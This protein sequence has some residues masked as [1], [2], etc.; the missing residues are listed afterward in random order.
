MQGS[1]IIV[2]SFTC[3]SF[4]TINIKTNASFKGSSRQWQQ[5]TAADG[6]E[7]SLFLIETPSSATAW[8]WIWSNAPSQGPRGM[9]SRPSTGHQHLQS[10]SK[11][12]LVGNE[13]HPCWATFMAQFK[14][15][16]TLFMFSQNLLYVLGLNY[17]RKKYLFSYEND[18]KTE[19]PRPM[20]FIRF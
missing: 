8:P 9:V 16:N 4:S 1:K 3:S 15:K 13:K 19:W 12:S 6:W 10:L 17:Y 7:K 14:N 20:S 2:C 5:K 18:N 11:G